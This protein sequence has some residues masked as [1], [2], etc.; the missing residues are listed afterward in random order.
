MK[1]GDKVGWN[2]V[3]FR[4]DNIG[5]FDTGNPDIRFARQPGSPSGREV[6]VAG[7]VRVAD[8]AGMGEQTPGGVA[9]SAELNRQNQTPISMAGN[10]RY[11][12]L[13]VSEIEWLRKKFTGDAVPVEIA[14]RIPGGKNAVKGRDGKLVLAADIFGTVDKTDMAQAKEALKNAGYY[15]HEDPAWCLGAPARDIENERVRSENALANELVRLSDERVTGTTP[16]GQ[17][18]A[19][20]VYADKLAE[21][22][23][24][25]P[26]DAPGTA[27]RIR[28][29]GDALRRRVRGNEAEA[30]T[31]LDWAYGPAA[32]PRTPSQRSAG[33]FGAFMVMPQEVQTKAPNYAA[34]IADTITADP[35]L[36]EA[37]RA[38]M[39][40]GMSEQSAAAVARD[41]RESFKREHER[42]VDA[43]EAEGVEPI[44]PG[45]IRG[46]LA[47]KL[48]VGFSDA[49]GT[50]VVRIDERI[51]A[52]NKAKKKALRAARTPAEKDAI[53]AEIDR[54]MGDMKRLKGRIELSQTAYERGA[55]NEDLVYLYKMRDL[56]DRANLKWGLSEADKVGYLDMKRTIETQGRAGSYGISPR[57][58]QLAL[59]Q[60]AQ[61][62]GPATYA[63]LE[64]YGREFHAIIEK[65]F[66]DD[67]RLERMF[68]KG[69]VDYCRT[70]TNYVTAKRTWSPEELEAI[71][72]A[73]EEA[74]RR[75]VAGGDDV[76]SQ[77][78]DYTRKVG[79]FTDVLKGSMAAKKDVRG[80]TWEKHLAI[81]QAVRRNELVLDM[82]EALL[83]AGVEGVRDVRRGDAFKGN[84]RYGH[85]KYLIN[86]QKRTLVVPRQIADGFNVNPRSANLF[87]TLAT[88]A[89][90]GY[91]DWNLGFR[92]VNNPIYDQSAY[93]WKMPGAREPIPQT[94]LKWTVPGGDA[95]FGI[96]S[97]WMSRK[98]PGFAS[99][100]GKDTIFR[101]FPAA[102]AVVEYLREPEKWMEKFMK[103]EQSRDWKTM[104]ELQDARDNA[105]SA[106][107]ANMFLPASSQ[108]LTGKSEGFA[109]DV[110]NVKGIKTTAQKQE[111]QL[112]KS[113]T[114]KVLEWVNIFKRNKAGIEADDMITKMAA[115]LHDRIAF[116]NL[117]TPQE[118]GVLVKQNIATPDVVRRGKHTR[119][120]QNWVFQFF[121]AAEKGIEGFYR[122]AKN[123]P[124]DFWSRFANV[125]GA[126][127]VSSLLSAGVIWK[128]M[129]DDC[130]G[131]EDN[132]KKKY[133]MFYDYAKW[134]YRA[135]QNPSDYQKKNYAHLPFWLSADGYTTLSLTGVIS[136]EDR[137]VTPWADYV[138]QNFAHKAGI[139]V[140]PSFVDPLANTTI[141]SVVPDLALAAPQWKILNTTIVSLWSNPHDMFTGRDYFSKDVWESRFDGGVGSARFAAEVGMRLW[142]DLGGRAVWEF[143]QEKA[144]DERN[145]APEGVIDVL[146]KFPVVSS[147]LRRCIKVSVGSPEKRGAAITEAYNQRQRIIRLCAKE[148]LKREKNN[149]WLFRTDMAEY[150]KLKT[151]WMKDYNLNEAAWVEVEEKYINASNE[152]AYWASEDAKTYRSLRT[153]A[154]K[155][156]IDPE[157][158]DLMLG[159]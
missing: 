125:F 148:L 151:K 40:R 126:R 24:A 133:G 17:A 144:G 67:P 69:W 59:D 98:V 115:Y 79:E 72:L 88:I 130:D 99:L 131:D 94:A 100:F 64:R 31:F 46:K 106:L 35:K 96:V 43:M 89:R 62:L 86:G 139:G 104:R 26:S 135:G 132:A 107:K 108:F 157:T 140:E 21:V 29:I 56:E 147:A 57:Q 52:Y 27:G 51:R 3:S 45:D 16:G 90:S 53:K 38:V 47:E 73:R 61:R 159:D 22:I 111:Q 58:A 36:E 30:D 49:M 77:M 1:D 34:A 92:L 13:P 146:S 19:R 70:Q 76:V 33:M 127:L 41:I 68:G 9:A 87:G 25:L 110:L 155:L 74:R 91:I 84:A 7:K 121:N 114:R 97:Q 150:Q 71:E 153:K 120:I 12:S 48:V 81:K 143:D 6:F 134:R 82:K 142:N 66:L 101:Y 137:L 116:G 141:K 23:L 63:N 113:K 136:M 18:A 39:L 105:L 103:A 80:A 37:W 83:A 50:T 65:D 117:R 124:K 112:A 138:A 152:R 118:S 44:K 75:G 129:L 158:V 78:Y 5:S 14:S 32:T 55:W 54:F 128:A 95:I 42:A 109:N 85:L 156:G 102:K 15:R 4:D 28:R 10:M 8:D 154:G 122:S 11:I 2:Y 149:E 145:A 93:V 119:I 123:N 60:M 20:G